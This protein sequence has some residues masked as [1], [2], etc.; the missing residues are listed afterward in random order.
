MFIVVREQLFGEHATK[1]V[2]I[3]LAA[4]GGYIMV[5]IIVLLRVASTP[6]F[7]D[8]KKNKRD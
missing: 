8:T 7:S 3:F 2:K 4:Y 1:D 5:P 6:L